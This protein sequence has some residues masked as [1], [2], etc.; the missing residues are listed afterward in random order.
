MEIELLRRGPD[1]N[2]PDSPA[3]LKTPDHLE[4]ASIGFTVPVSDIY[5]TTGL[6]R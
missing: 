6:S 5:R 1:G 4:L 2:W 3:I